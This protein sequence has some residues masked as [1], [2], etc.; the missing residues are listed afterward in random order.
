MFGVSVRAW[1]ATF[2]IITVCVMS[3]IGHEV[4]EPLYSAMLLA[5]GFY[6]G[7]KRT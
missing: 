2:L 4:K 6:F 3:G 1:L 7:Q 5:L